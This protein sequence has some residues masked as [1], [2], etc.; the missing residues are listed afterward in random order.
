MSTAGGISTKFHGYGTDELLT[1]WGIKSQGDD[2]ADTEALREH[3]R[4][5]LPGHEL[6]DHLPEMVAD[7]RAFLRA[8]VK[9]ERRLGYWAPVWRGL[10]NI[11]KG[12]PGDEVL[13]KASILLV[14]QMWT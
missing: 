5:H 6:H 4:K 2:A 7:L 12:E 3:M 9:E 11:E 1:K 13:L 8:L 10:L 14:D